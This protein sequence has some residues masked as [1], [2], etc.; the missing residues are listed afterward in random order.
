M[1]PGILN[2]LI[3]LGL[4][5][6]S[7]FH[8]TLIEGR[9]WHLVVA[10]VAIVVLA[11]WARRRDAMKWFS[12]TTIVLGVLLLLFGILQWTTPIAH[13]VNFWFVF[14]DGILIAV[15]S[16]WAALYGPDISLMTVDSQPGDRAN[17]RT[18]PDV[19]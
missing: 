16:L 2:T 14:F 8:L 17:N 11:L 7:V 10:G 5:Y 6:F 19:H 3:G 13:L 4:V 1:I 15:L 12:T 9:V 18:R